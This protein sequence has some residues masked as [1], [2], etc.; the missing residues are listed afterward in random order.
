MYDLCHASVF[1]L[2][3]VDGLT[4]NQLHKACTG[5]GAHLSRR[6]VKGVT[7][8][9]V[10]GSAA[11]DLLSGSRM[12]DMLER[13]PDQALL[14]SETQLQRSLGLRREPAPIA[15]TLST[16]ELCRLSGLDEDYLFW[17]ALFD[18]VEAV[19]GMHS[20]R[21]LVAARE[22]A[23]LL[24]AGGDLADVVGAA[25]DLRKEGRSLSDVR[26]AVTRYG[27]LARSIDGVQT[28]MKGQYGLPLDTPPE[29]VDD[30]I[31]CAEEA[32]EEGDLDTAERLYDLG[33][34]LDRDDPLIPFNLG[35]VQDAAGRLAEARI[36]WRMAIDRA[37]AFP[38][39]WFNL[40]VSAEDAGRKDE[41][42]GHYLMALAINGDFADA[43]YNLALALHDLGRFAEALPV[44]ERFIAMEPRSE[45]ARLARHKAADCRFRVRGLVA[46]V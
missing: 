18:V 38:E 25:I 41:A 46:A 11:R 12:M 10:T 29:N 5:A 33:C 24:R 3:H 20:Y 28:D 36:S 44:W 26:L 6:L 15:R 34:K 40:G 7:V 8:V 19:E 43:A 27:E 45:D 2:G 14:I 32:E 42:V 9:A 16:A 1:V 4:R 30:V 31:E 17:L 22:V 23:R 37:P 39:A 21:D 13:I 35:N